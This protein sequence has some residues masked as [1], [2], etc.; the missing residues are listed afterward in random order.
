MKTDCYFCVINLTGI[1]RNNRSSLK[2][3][4]LQS[5]R[6]NVAHCDETPVPVFGELPDISEKDSSD[7]EENK[8]EVILDNDAPYPFPQM[9]LNDLVHD[10]SLS[11]S[12]AE[13]NCLHL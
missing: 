13:L 5:A 4:D 11:R 9:E 8:E 12:P 7:V 6:R 1:N 2:Y 3:P 10:L